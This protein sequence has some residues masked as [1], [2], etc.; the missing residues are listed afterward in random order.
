MS[1]GSSHKGAVG[2]GGAQHLSPRDVHIGQRI[3]QR[4]LLIGLSLV[5]MAA[6]LGISEDLLES[7][8]LGEA[9]IDLV[10]LIRIA[11]VLGVDINFFNQDTSGRGA[12]AA[13]ARTGSPASRDQAAVQMDYP[14]IRVKM[15]RRW[16]G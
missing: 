9:W 3:R 8:E 7:Y 14:I 4:R 5:S 1:E 11:E 13:S 6:E 10:R 15:R 2:R 16:L 12:S